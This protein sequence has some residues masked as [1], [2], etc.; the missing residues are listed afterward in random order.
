MLIKLEQFAP[1]AD[2]TVPG[3]IIDLDGMVPTVKGYKAAP[4]AVDA[5]SAALASECFGA[6]VLRKLD[7]TTRVIAGTATKLYEL[8]SGAWS[9]VSGAAYNAAADVRWSFA[10]FGNVSLASTKGDKIQQSSSGAFAA[11]SAAPKAGTIETVNQFVFAGN[12]NDTGFGDSPD[13]WWCCA[14]G[15][16]TDWTPNTNTLCVSGRL[17]SAPGRINLLKRLGDGIVAYKDRSMF[18]GSFVG[19]PEAWSFQEIPG[20]VGCPSPQGVVDIGAA[21]LFVGND[22]N[23]WMFDGSRPTPIGTPIKEWFYSNLYSEYAY[24]IQSVHDRANALV[25]FF[26][27][28]TSGGGTLDSCVVYNYRINKWGVSD[29]TIEA[30]IDYVSGGITYTSTYAT[31]TTFSA[32]SSVSF[33]SQ[34]LTNGQPVP[35]YI[36]TS[37]A[38]QF[39]NGVGGS[40]SLTTNDFGDDAQV[41]TITQV[42]PRFL[43]APSTSTLVNYYRMTMGDSLTTDATTTL[44]SGRYD[45]IRAARWHRFVVS[46]TGGEISGLNVIAEVSGSE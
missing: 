4:T 23:F 1:D 39:I 16:Y 31:T 3:T 33:E 41:T 10:Q 35:S 37:H 11:I 42:R 9:D 27:P 13:R 28:S 12:T 5:G 7:N 8:S 36:D 15:D 22:G 24:R 25:Y 6:A 19:A 18:I 40:W 46:G 29:R 38:I 45:F 2:F 32:A 21:H 14:E 17:T 44:G 34:F 30:A 20:Q 26:Y 43:T